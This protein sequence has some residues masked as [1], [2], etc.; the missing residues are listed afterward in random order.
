MIRALL[1][2]SL[3]MGGGVNTLYA[4]ENLPSPMHQPQV[5]QQLSCSHWPADKLLSPTDAAMPDFLKGNP[6]CLQDL[7]KVEFAP[8]QTMK[9]YSDMYKRFNEIYAQLDDTKSRVEFTLGFITE[10]SKIHQIGITKSIHGRYALQFG[11][12][13]NGYVDSM[14]MFIT[15]HENDGYQLT[16]KDYLDFGDSV[17]NTAALK[18]R[19]NYVIH[20]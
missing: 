4:E 5:K 17:V 10:V 2:I 18:S 19:I 9:E 6:S 1:I 16:E 11:I 13:L 15:S 8:K 3:G 14:L 7:K 20:G 12:K